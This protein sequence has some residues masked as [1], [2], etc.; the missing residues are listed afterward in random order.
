MACC[1]VLQL[2]LNCYSY[3]NLLQKL[4]TLSLWNLRISHSAL[5]DICKTMTHLTYLC[6]AGVLHDSRDDEVLRVIST[7]MPQ[8][9]QLDISNCKVSLG[10][11][12]YLL[13]TKDDPGRGCPELEA[14]S[15]W[16]IKNIDVE[17]L[18]KII[19]GLPKLRYISHLLMVNVLAELTDEEAI[20]GSFKCLN[21]L[22]LPGPSSWN[23]SSIGIDLRYDIL[24]KVPK[25]ASTCNITNVDISLV[26]HSTISITDLLMPLTKLDSLTLHG[27]SKGHEGLLTVLESR[28]HQLR[29][30]H[31]FSVIETVSLP[32]IARTCLL[33]HQFTMTYA[34]SP[35][36]SNSSND[37]KNQTKQ[38]CGHYGFYYLSE[39]TLGHFSEQLC[40][41]G[42][43]A[44]LLGSLY[45]KTINLTDV[46]GLDNAAMSSVQSCS[47]YRSSTLT[48][49]EH[50]GIKK[51]R[52]ITAEA[53]VR[54]L[55]TEGTMLKNLH[56]KDCDKVDGDV[57]H[58]AVVKYPRPL[59]V[60]VSGSNLP[61]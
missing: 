59:N 55:N 44:L 17:F 50:F 6:L 14:I 52:N 27:L 41:S 32:D 36:D 33:L 22:S 47:L 40:S 19:L 2:F 48:S 13:P 24:Q 3:Y 51:C 8:L 10:A 58:E 21:K 25:F 61:T 42:M 28:G 23:N 31:L 46:E 7:C 12:R 26:R 38:K 57:L 9:Q 15:L 56:I 54:L 4:S 43:L 60:T 34:P 16:E 11:I 5:L 29:S 30:L 1:Q 35:S 49:V 18:K 45:L 39:L 53:F 37:H 20:S